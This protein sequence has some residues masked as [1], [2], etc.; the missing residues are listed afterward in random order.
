MYVYASHD[1]DDQMAYEML[2]YHIFSSDDLV[3]WQDHGVALAAGD[4]WAR[5]L[6]A[7]DCCYSRTSGKYY[8]YF[9][10]SGSG[11]G[12][13]VADSPAG[14]FRDALGKPLIDNQTPG[15]G[16]VDWISIRPAHRRR[17]SGLPYFAEAPNTGETRGH[18]LDAD[19][20]SMATSPP[21]PSARL[22]SSSLVFAQTCGQYYF[23]YSPT[24]ANHAPTTTTC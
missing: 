11:I 22:T 16:D 17:W 23:S 1:P 18:S 9:P 2:D 8:L 6:Y 24:Y 7:P 13:A 14:P 15:V 10:D 5:Y 21:P 20:T 19:M 3:N 12:V 4:T